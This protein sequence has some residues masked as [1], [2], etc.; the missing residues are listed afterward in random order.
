[1]MFRLAELPSTHAAGPVTFWS[2]L[3]GVFWDVHFSAEGGL[4]ACDFSGEESL[5]W[6]PEKMPTWVYVF[7]LGYCIISF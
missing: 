2:E 7:K 4:K 6:F 3:W 5:V 1:M